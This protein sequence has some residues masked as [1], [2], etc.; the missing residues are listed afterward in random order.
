[1]A[2]IKITQES[3]ATAFRRAGA[4]FMEAE[5]ASKQA[6]RFKS[7]KQQKGPDAKQGVE[8][9]YKLLRDDVFGPTDGPA[10]PGPQPLDAA[11]IE[12]ANRIM[13]DAMKRLGMSGQV[14]KLGAA[15]LDRLSLDLKGIDYEN[16]VKKVAGMA[17]W[18]S[19]AQ[20]LAEAEGLDV[21][22]MTWEDTSRT[23][24][25]VWGDNITDFY[26]GVETLNARSGQGKTFNMP[27]IRRSNF[28]DPTADI[29]LEKFMINVGNA[30]GEAPRQI[31]LKEALKEPWKLMSDPE[32]WP[33]KD[34]NGK[35]QG[36]YSPGV[37]E[38]ALVSSQAAFLPVTK[39]G[40][41]AVYKP[42]AHNYQSHLHKDKG[43]QPAI[44]TLMVTPEG[45]SVAILGKEQSGRGKAYGEALYFNQN[46]ERAP[47]TAE[48]AS[49]S[50]QAQEP[51]AV[52]GGDGQGNA[53]QLNRLLVIQIPLIP[54]VKK[55]AWGGGG[56]MFAMAAG[57]LESV[58]GGSDVE[59]AVI[60]H[61]PIEGPFDETM[62]AGWKRDEAKPI[63]VTVQLTKATS[64]GVITAEQMKE[65][66]K[67]L[68]EVYKNA[69]RVGSLV[70]T[71]TPAN[72]GPIPFPPMPP[73]LPLD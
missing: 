2:S 8:N 37:D 48:R 26:I 29:D 18:R 6:N 1:M 63:R 72:P 57:G 49:K 28:E 44:L 70:V 65:I 67:E 36:V 10:G 32:K 24:N 53:S 11:G 23:P 68:D 47:L 39:K 59:D 61:G 17:D 30:Q 60:G 38:E 15:A 21:V 4:N 16:M 27:V 43:P 46:G 41:R 51:G 22:S 62:G 71:E 40:G 42:H 64:N 7:L 69:S 25:S 3:V 13:F 33:L 66:R 35:K 14:R 45:T 31:S 34:A 56:I 50:K 58:G 9:L 73:I 55:P 19:P 20:K 54:E 12:R 52:V 5:L